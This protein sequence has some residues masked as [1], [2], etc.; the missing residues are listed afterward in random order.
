MTRQKKDENF[1][2]TIQDTVISYP[3]DHL[4]RRS[5]QEAIKR[6]ITIDFS[7]PTIF[8]PN[9]VTSFTHGELQGSIQKRYS[10]LINGSSEEK[11]PEKQQLK[12]DS[13]KRIESNLLKQISSGSGTEKIES[14][15][16]YY[17]NIKQ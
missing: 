4:Y 5:Y 12:Q 11:E 3:Q 1:A 15:G 13:M 16:N 14:K 9:I 2:A 7:D 8:Q 17:I 10:T 6:P